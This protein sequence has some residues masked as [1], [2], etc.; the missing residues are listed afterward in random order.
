MNGELEEV[1]HDCQGVKGFQREGPTK[2]HISHSSIF[3]ARYMAC[4]YK[5]GQRNYLA[6][7]RRDVTSRG[8]PAE[9]DWGVHL[10]PMGNVKRGS[11]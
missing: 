10:S 9:P 8:A 3:G 5:G 6:A 7:Q 4:Q 11:Q 2:V 1:D